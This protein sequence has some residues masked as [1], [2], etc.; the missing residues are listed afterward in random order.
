MVVDI[1]YC[2]E[3][4][5]IKK[6]KAC[7]PPQAYLIIE[8]IEVLVPEEYSLIRNLVCPFCGRKFPTRPAL[9]IHLK[10]GGNG[11][12]AAF[13]DLVNYL[14]EAYYAARYKVYKCG[15]KT[16]CY[17]NGRRMRF[18]T[19]FEGIRAVWEKE[20]KIKRITLCHH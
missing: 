12:S 1:R 8:M 20:F 10:R 11:C 2:I 14:V 6:K 17:E 15:S 4:I 7:S 13:N 16:W 18:K 9:A 5:F 3:N 19:K